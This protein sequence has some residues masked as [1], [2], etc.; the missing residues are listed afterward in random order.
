MT[1]KE[2]LLAQQQELFLLK[3]MLSDEKLTFAEWEMILP[4]LFHVNSLEESTWVYDSVKAREFEQ[5]ELLPF[6]IEQ[7]A[8]MV[9]ED[10]LKE[11]TLRYV[12]FCCGEEY[13]KVFGAFRKMTIE[14]KVEPEWLYIITKF[15]KGMATAISLSIPVRQMGRLSQ[16]ITGLLDD[17]LFIKQNYQRFAS[18]TKQECLILKLIVSGQKRRHIAEQLHI[19]L[20]TYDTHRKNIRQKLDVKSVSELIRYAQAFGL[21]EE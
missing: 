3:K 20:H 2:A 4:A 17:N 12:D 8:S 14:G 19:S 7:M 9:T 15:Y 13:C 1:E 16:Q 11:G 5:E 21:G 6:G 10:T 18:L